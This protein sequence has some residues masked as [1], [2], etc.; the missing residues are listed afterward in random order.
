VQILLKVHV[1][2]SADPDHWRGQI[3]TYFSDDDWTEWFASYTEFILY[4]AALAQRM[5]V[6]VF[7]VGTELSVTSF[8]A[9]QWRAV[10]KKIRLVYTGP[11]VFASNWY[12]T[13]LLAASLDVRCLDSRRAP[14]FRDS[15]SMP[16]WDVLDFIGVDAYFP[17]TTVADPSRTQLT[18]AWESIT[19]VLA[20]LSSQYNHKPI[21]FTEIGYCSDAG[22]NITPY[23]CPNPVS[24]DL[25]EQ[26]NDY[27]AVF[28]NVVS[29]SW[30]AGVYWW[31][32]STNPDAGGPTDAGY[33]PQNKPAEAVLASNYKL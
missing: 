18:Q 27:Q 1:D 10:V 26:A 8:H 21:L 30:F 4:Q 2:L 7:C 6:D 32:W 17:L 16:W 15:I 25:T 22:S 33:S 11:L 20:N 23:S 29:Q 31:A 9:D 3:G 19:P 5:Q 12:L 28:D 13:C 14:S 24:L